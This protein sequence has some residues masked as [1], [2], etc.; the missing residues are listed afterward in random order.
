M[1]MSYKIALGSAF[2]LCG[3]M[4]SIYISNVHTKTPVKNSQTI[5]P[6][7]IADMQDLLG[8]AISRT[9][10]PTPSPTPLQNPKPR[11]TTPKPR[12]SVKPADKTPTITLDG[13]GLPRKSVAASIAP[14]PTPTP[15]ATAVLPTRSAP[16]SSKIPA[17]LK[18][19]TYIILPGDTLVSIA[20]EE[21]GHE[22]H[23]VDIAQANPLKDP[24]RLY[25][26]DVIKLPDT[27]QVKKQ[28]QIT[29]RRADG[30]RI[31]IVRGG[32]TL[33]GISKTHYGTTAHWRIIYNTNRAK[34]G[35]DPNRVQ[36]GSQ[37]IIPRP[38]RIP[39]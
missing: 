35:N 34:I 11:A 5:S 12:P 36:A 19:R 27:T 10:K 23:W 13:N 9:P 18:L 1:K 21:Y 4:L 17:P 37:L 16:T 20:T 15:V 8:P 30:S 39:R 33:T 22:K 24:T 28:R 2:V 29:L 31:H 25:P 14:R 38:P 32:D 6:P 26:G 3:A 7:Q